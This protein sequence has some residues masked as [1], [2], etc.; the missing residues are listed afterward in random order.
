MILAAWKRPVSYDSLGDLPGAIIKRFAEGA[1]HGNHRVRDFL[2]GAALTRRS[3][4]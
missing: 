2:V 1:D 4:A 3:G